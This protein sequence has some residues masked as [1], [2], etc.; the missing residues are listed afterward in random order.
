METPKKSS[1]SLHRMKMLKTARKAKNAAKKRAKRRVNAQ[2]RAD[3]N[4]ARSSNVMTN[5]TW[6]GFDANGN[7]RT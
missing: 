3:T 5:R 4:R 7:Y 6:H 2:L 1:M